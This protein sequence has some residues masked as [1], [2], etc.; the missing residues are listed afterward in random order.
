MG[1]EDTSTQSHS[2]K[3]VAL[4]GATGFVGKRL[5][6]LL[7]DAGFNVRALTR[8]P[9]TLN[10]KNLT[11][12]EGD[13]QNDT[14]LTSLTKNVD[15]IIH[16]AGLVK[17]L[18][19]ADFISVNDGG[20]ENLIKALKT[21]AKENAGSKKE[22]RGSSAVKK[23]DGVQKPFFIH[24][25]S[26]AAREPSLSHYA[27]SK[28][29]SEQ[30]VKDALPDGGYCIIRPPAVYGPGDE[31][32]QKV[33]DPMLKL[34]LAPKAGFGDSRFSLIYVDDL[35]RALIKA[36][37]APPMADIYELDDFGHDQHHHGYNTGQLKNIV[38]SFS[39]RSVMT[40]TMP[41][42]LIYLLGYL[43]SLWAQLTR[44]PA[45][46]THKKAAE[47]CHPN[48]VVNHQSLQSF[49]DQTSWSPSTTLEKGLA[50]TLGERSNI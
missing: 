40:I 42:T 34:G 25:S 28:H 13:L 18:R 26:L 22:G 38:T 19:R 10:H 7:L 29:L 49:M 14:A 47:I 32:F 2:I 15:A 3:S 50:K 39:G 48:W 45:M 1:A 23:T 8:R 27:Y 46:L 6:P 37:K 31:E 35:A 44:K 20:T 9:Q 5:I 24:V 11:W 41:K 12:V 17:A 16:M 36:L 21:Q 33:L 43:G 30:T 4:T